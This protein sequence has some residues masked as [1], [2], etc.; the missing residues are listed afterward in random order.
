MNFDQV[1]SRDEGA[2]R[3]VTKARDD[4]GNLSG[5][6]WARRWEPRGKRLVARPHWLPSA[7]GWRHSSLPQPWRMGAPLPTRMC[8]LDTHCAAL[9]MYELR[10]APQHLAVRIVPDTEV[11][12]TDAPF[13]G[14]GG[15]LSKHK[16]GAAD[17]T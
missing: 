6:E 4:A 16:P 1:E 11:L 5:A 13:S 8:Q 3:R 17:G 15:G 2:R 9:T 14:H 12:R 7:I 10:D